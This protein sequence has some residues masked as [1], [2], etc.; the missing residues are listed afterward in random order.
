MTEVVKDKGFALVYPVTL[1]Y[2]CNPVPVELHVSPLSARSP[3]PRILPLPGRARQRPSS[4][5]SEGSE[6]SG[7]SPPAA[8][9]LF[10]ELRL[11]GVL[12]SS[13]RGERPEFL[14]KAPLLFSLTL[15]FEIPWQQR[16]SL[17]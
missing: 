14:L 1:G 3:P 5:L 13:A 16:Q 9:R 11:N 10:T 15:F 2:V 7:T 12:R 4:R 17:G 6:R 8:R